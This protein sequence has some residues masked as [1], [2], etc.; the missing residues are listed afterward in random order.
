MDYVVTHLWTMQ[1]AVWIANITESCKGEELFSLFLEEGENTRRHCLALAGEDRPGNSRSV[2]DSKSLLR[3]LMNIASAGG[4]KCMI[5]A[6]H[7]ILLR[8]AERAGQA[9]TPRGE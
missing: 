8:P 2:L 4:P 1:I 7:D 6:R 5:L 9:L 3:H